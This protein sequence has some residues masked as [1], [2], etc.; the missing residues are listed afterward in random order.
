MN[1]I[2]LDDGIGVFENAVPLD[3]CEGLISH[4]EYLNSLGK[5]KTRQ[6]GLEGP[7]VTRDDISV[8]ISVSNK[9]Q[10]WHTDNCTEEVINLNNHYQYNTKRI[11]QP[12][13]E[14]YSHKYY[15][16]NDLER[17]DMIYMKL[18]KTKP[19]QGYHL[20]HTEYSKYQPY[21]ILATMIYLNDIDEGGETE[22]L[23]QH[24]RIKPKAGTALIWPAYFTHPHRGN[25]PL[26][27]DKYILTSWYE[28]I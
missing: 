3:F 18:Q 24:K 23:F 13:Y 9:F 15:F 1:T 20:W 22:F 16:L 7:K 26:S 21:R 14:V 6:E 8:S 19:G 28:F 17:H 25:P 5:A 2:T 11:L 4:F 12:C 10:T 27:K